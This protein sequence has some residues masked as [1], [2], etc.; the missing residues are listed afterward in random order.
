MK[1]SAVFFCLLGIVAGLE[2][3]SKKAAPYEHG[4]VMSAGYIKK[5]FGPI[6]EFMDIKSGTTFADFGAGSGAITVMMATLM[7]SSTIYI[8]DIDTAFLN[9]QNL[10][11]IIEYHSGQGKR[12]LAGIHKFHMIVGTYTSTELPDS[13][14]DVIYTNGTMHVISSL[15]S[16]LSDLK[17]KLRPDGRLFIRDSFSGDHKA[18]PFCKDDSCGKR[19]LTIPEFLQIMNRN[20]YTVVKHSADMSGYPLFGFA[21]PE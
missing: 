18:G 9:Q 20:G 5:T 3:C 10:D 2:S 17:T 12:D 13:T 6:L 15:D 7:D 16:I 4:P 14:F 21:V 19:L 11:K 1:R 8:Q